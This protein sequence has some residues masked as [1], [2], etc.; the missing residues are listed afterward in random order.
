VQI[1][2]TAECV[3]KIIAFGDH[4]KR[5]FDD[6]WNIFDF[7]IVIVGWFESVLPFN[8]SI[9]RLVKLLRVFKLARSFPSLRII[10]EVP[11]S[12]LGRPRN[13]SSCCLSSNTIPCLRLRRCSMR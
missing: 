12:M 5:Y 1:I 10:V 4:P 3:V 9:L 11:P 8:A 6:S 7:S 13:R 2:F